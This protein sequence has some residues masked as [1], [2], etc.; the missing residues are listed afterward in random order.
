[1]TPAYR[2]RYDDAEHKYYIGADEIPSVTTIL[3]AA[4]KFTAAGYYTED[5]RRRGKAV[6]AACQAIDLDVFDPV[7]LEPAYAG[8]VQSYQ[9]FLD[10]FKP[11]WQMIE[12]AMASRRHGFGGKA[13]RIGIVAAPAILEIK[14][15]TREAWHGYQLAG[16]DV[17]YHGANVN[18]H[19]RIA[20][21]LD[22]DGRFPRVYEYTKSTDYDEWFECLT[23]VTAAA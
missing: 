5:S 18:F 7:H 2:F 16:Y 10:E 12:Q 17:L 20:V 9:R 22:T 13:D 3:S 19:R 11:R 23:K 6:H 4:G 8:F 21:Y 14:T 15:G 1:M